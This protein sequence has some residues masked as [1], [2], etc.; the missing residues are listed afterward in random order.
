VGV[1]AADVAVES[2]AGR[3][4]AVVAAGDDDVLVDDRRRDETERAVDVTADA[5]LQ[6]DV[7]ALAE[8]GRRLPRLRIQGHQP[9]ARPGEDP[10]RGRGVT[11]PIGDA[12]TAHE[13]GR[14]EPPELLAC[15]RLQSQ[16]VLA[17]GDEHPAVHDE[18]SDLDVR[19]ARVDHPRLLQGRDV[20][21]GNLLQ[22]REAL[23]AEVTVVRGPIGFVRGDRK[24]QKAHGQSHRAEQVPVH[25]GDYLAP[26]PAAFSR[27]IS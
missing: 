9:V 5:G 25:D 23:A 7:S 24:R 10:R 16:H 20:L 11:R 3:L 18:R 2:V 27:R 17:R 1:P 22:R 19:R 21:G 15:L 8:A 14:G 4:L 26:W 6:V 12:A 13:R